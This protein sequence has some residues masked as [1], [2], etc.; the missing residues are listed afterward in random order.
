M[1]ITELAIALEDSENDKWFDPGDLCEELGVNSW[2]IDQTI[3]E[4]DGRLTKHWNQ[5]WMC[6]DTMVGD[7]IYYFD[8][9]A[10]AYS[11]QDARKSDE[12][13]HFFSKE[14]ALDAQAYLMSLAKKECQIT[15]A[16][17]TM[18][19]KDYSGEVAN[20]RFYNGY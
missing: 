15:I 11:H 8:C 20:A 10:L 5:K 9:K 19:V 2:D 4:N 13:F 7:A 3:L 17:P 14:V 6:T 1:N 16:E 12:H 18:E